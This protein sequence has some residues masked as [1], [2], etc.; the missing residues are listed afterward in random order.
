MR[1]GVPKETLPGE[2]RVALIPAA[3]GPLLKAGLQVAVEQS[4]GE[5]AGFPDDAYRAQ[6]AV[7]VP[8]AEVFQ[9]ADVILQVRST[10]PDAALRSGQAVIGFADPLGAPPALRAP[11]RRGRDDAVDGADAAHHPRAEHGRAVVDGHH[12]RLQGRAARRQPAAAHVPDAH[13]R[14]R[15]RLAGARLHRRRRRRRA[16]GDRVGATPRRAGSKPTTCGRRSRNRC[17]AWARGSSSCRSSRPTRRTRAATPRRRTRRST[18]A[19]AR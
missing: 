18:D 4:A 8:R 19:S 2:T 10:P 13:D 14:R 7:V 1:I 15:H 9:T 6:G 5:A 11:R 16:A 12:R 17:R 3:V